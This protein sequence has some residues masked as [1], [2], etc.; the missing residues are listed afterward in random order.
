MLKIHRWRKDA[1]MTANDQG[2]SYRSSDTRNVGAEASRF[3]DIT[4]RQKRFLEWSAMALTLVLLS[5]GCG[6]SSGNKQTPRCALP[7]D[8]TGALTC[9][10]GFCVSACVQSKDCPNGE[11][12]IPAAEGVGNSCQPPERT[13]CSYTSQ[14][15]RPLVCGLDQQCRAQCQSDIDC[16][17]QQR[18]TAVTKLCADPTIDKNYDPVTNEF[19]ATS[20]PDGGTA[21]DG[22]VVSPR[23]D[24][25]VGY[26]SSLAQPDAPMGGADVANPGVDAGVV[27]P[28]MDASMPGTD[29]SAS[30]DGPPVLADGVVVTPSPSVR[31][32]QINVTVTIT[33]AAGG[34]AS[35]AAFDMADLTVR[36]QAGSTDTSLVLKVSV[37]HGAPLGKRTLKIATAAGVI[38]AAD[39]VD[40][41]AITSAPTGSDT[42][43]AGSAASPF[44]TLKQAIL[45]ADVGDTIHLMDGTYNI[46][47]G[48]SWGYVIPDGLTI[49][50]DT[51]AGTVIDGVGATNNPNGF[52][53]STNLTLK[54]LTLQHFYYGIDMKQPA[55]TLT[56]QDVVLAGNANHA[57]YVEQAATGSTV[58]IL[59]K[60]TLIDQP[61]ETALA[62][63]NSPDTTVNITDAT[64]QGGSYVIYMAYN[65][66]GSKLTMTGGAVKQLGTYNAIYMGI[67]SNSVGT[68]ASFSNTTIVGNISNSDSK[69][70]L[71]ITGSNITQKSG[72]GIDFSGS[73]LALTNTT[74][75]M[76]GTSTG[77]YLSG[78]QSTMALTGVTIT[79]GGRG[80]QQSG[81]GSSAKLRGTTITGTTYDAYL[82]QAGDLDLGTE[83]ASGDN[84]IG[85]PT[86]TSYWCL[87]I[88]RPQGAAAGN[89]VTCSGTTLNGLAPSPGTIDASSGY[90]SLQPQ[91]YY[92]T[93]GNKLIFY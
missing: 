4:P 52:N 81:T 17:S 29:A 19:V 45:V 88:S 16:P 13:T 60:G 75:T 62:V 91:R 27:N 12:C 56:L 7:S 90:V 32:G 40:V 54:T 37:P 35:A 86:S 50:G 79:G 77:V 5:A 78:T 20:V 2:R 84:I 41:S 10:Q 57:I 6:G 63:Y 73:A 38:T 80:V 64:L 76:S 39:L 55:S 24:A 18:C 85:A 34:L 92:L 48:E 59:G 47:N 49:V 66:S 3:Q 72:N 33:R 58:N 31:Q 22:A 9:I 30:F 11:R 14:C 26:D 61:G 1:C 65:C 71:T 46:K 44:A 74:L 51:V 89:P 68:T 42:L 36:A 87:N 43:N 8:C 82:L 69:G 15:T 93:T 25:S 23:Y 67:S 70:S 53:A 21:V 28:G 83:T